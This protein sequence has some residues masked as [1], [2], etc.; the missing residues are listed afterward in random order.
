MALQVQNLKRV[1]ELKKDNK[2]VTL[3]DPNAELTAEEVVKFYSTTHPELTN[4]VITG[5]V[6]V[7]DKATYSIATRAGKLG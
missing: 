2:T 4:G 7:G 6:V 1:F 3:Q 5:P